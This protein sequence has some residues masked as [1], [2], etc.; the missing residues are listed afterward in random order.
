L[1]G[2]ALWF[3][4]NGLIEKPFWLDEAYSAYAADKGFGFIFTVLP[5]YETHPPFYS[6]VLSIWT[7]IFGNSL[8]AFRALGLFAG[9]MLLPLAW[10]ASKEIARALKLDPSLYA[11]AAFALLAAS[12]STVYITQLV[13]PYA[14]LVLAYLFGIFCIF[15][16]A[17]HYRETGKLNRKLWLGYLVSLA[18]SIWL[19]NLGVLYAAG[20]GLALL[21]LIGPVRL[22]RDHPRAFFIGHFAVLFVVLPAFLILLD[23]APTWRQS[24]WLRFHWDGIEEN[25]YTIYGLSGLVASTIA[26][27]I[28]GSAIFKSEKG[29][30]PIWLALLTLTFVPMLLSLLISVTIAPVFISRTL[31]PLSVAFILLVAAGAIV[32]SLINRVGFG[33]LLVLT[34][35]YLMAFQQMKPTENWYGAVAWLK[36]RI[37]PGDVVYAYPNEGALPLSYAL[38]DKRVSLPIRPIPGAVPAKDPT[39]WFPTGSRGVVSLPQYRL[40]AI[41]SDAQSRKIKTIWLLRLGASAYD[42]DDHFLNALMRDREDVGSWNE[43]PIDIIGL[44]QTTPASPQITPRQQAQP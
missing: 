24:T 4:L 26:A 13:R 15:K 34:I 10:F 31:A 27:L 6:A 19:H 33:V 35:I 7:K 20:L 16:L 41:A 38:R 40:E 23:Q 36:G 17:Y 9:I 29:A 25:L 42:K 32:P 12:P 11:L 5:S 28:V 14:L 37:E 22:I 44:R 39:G 30:L 43:E 8:T 1:I 18:L 3:R 2:A 21:I